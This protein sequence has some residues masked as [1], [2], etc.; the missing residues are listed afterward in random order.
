MFNLLGNSSELILIFIVGA[1]FVIV[2]FLGKLK[3]G[4]IDIGG[5]I[6]SMGAQ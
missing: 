3:I 2:G 4:S 6:I 5:G 1:G